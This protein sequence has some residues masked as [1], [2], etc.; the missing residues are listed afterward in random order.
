VNAAALHI[1]VLEDDPSHA[2][3]VERALVRAG[4]HAVIRVVDCADAFR[5]AL[6]E[7]APDLV[8]SDHSGARFTALHALGLVRATRPGTPV[9]LVSG[10]F[11]EMVVVESLKAGA[12]DY[13]LKDRLDRLAPAIRAALA[14][15]Q[16]LKLLTPRQV[17]VMQLLVTGLST[18]ET[19]GRL[20]ISN[21]T[22]ETH[23][24]AL[25][26]RLGIH[27]VPEL[28]RYALRIG[29]APLE[30]ETSGRPEMT[31]RISGIA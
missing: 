3:L 11:N 20:G 17:E 19:A 25:M 14:L 12:E 10:A 22:V 23:R 28:V 5:R 31:R 30:P 15:R 1:L 7:F 4:I 21:K 2:E 9:I 16:P 13:V 24:M 18:R 27:H 6:R 29:L 8:L 26:M